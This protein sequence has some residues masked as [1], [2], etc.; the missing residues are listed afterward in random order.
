[1]K[2]KFKHLMSDYVSLKKKIKKQDK[3]AA[4]LNHGSF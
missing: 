3:D 4:N 2:D 1:M